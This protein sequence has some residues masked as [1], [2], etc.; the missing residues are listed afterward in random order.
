MI[1]PQS[2]FSDF[3]APTST[4]FRCSICEREHDFAPFLD[5]NI[6]FA[7]SLGAWNSDASNF[8]SSSMSATIVSPFQFLPQPMRIR[9]IFLVRLSYRNWWS[10]DWSFVEVER[11]SIV[12]PNGIIGPLNDS[13]SKSPFKKSF[14]IRQ[15][16][17][18][19]SQIAI[20]YHKI[21]PP[22]CIQSWW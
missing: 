13:F 18:D 9:G 4:Q 8:P 22:S 12:A 16:F 6:S 19:I 17:L 11:C 15:E 20:A 14:P 2:W 10:L 1:L 7:L 21:S 5:V 3:M